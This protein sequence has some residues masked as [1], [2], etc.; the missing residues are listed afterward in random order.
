MQ[1]GEKKWL[2]ERTRWPETCLRL[3]RKVWLQSTAS[4]YLRLWGN[5]DLTTGAGGCF[6]VTVF[7]WPWHSRPTSEG[8]GP[9]P[10]V[11]CEAG[12]DKGGQ[13]DGDAPPRPTLP[14]HTHTHTRWE[15]NP[16]DGGHNT[17]APTQA[18][19]PHQHSPTPQ[20]ISESMNSL[21]KM[22]DWA[23]YQE[24]FCIN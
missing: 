1:V 10:P 24:G 16:V 21:L 6:Q 13:G 4:I 20:F 7:L 18:V 8:P 2:S 17:E 15:S 9:L 23:A 14:Y 3:G 19:D 12:G 22:E 5:V 11:W